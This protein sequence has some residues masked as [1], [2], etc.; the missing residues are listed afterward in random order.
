MLEGLNPVLPCKCKLMIKPGLWT[1]K[2]KGLATFKCALSEGCTEQVQ[3][4]NDICKSYYCKGCIAKMVASAKGPLLCS[5]GKLQKHYIPPKVCFDVDVAKAFTIYKGCKL[6]TKTCM[7]LAEY[8]NSCGCVYCK[9]CLTKFCNENKAAK[10]P[11]GIGT[12]IISK[13]IMI[14]LGLI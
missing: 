14:Q 2:N 13:E 5:C 9:D 1:P 10:C 11:C 3:F 6:E 4:V 12:D 7:N 8:V